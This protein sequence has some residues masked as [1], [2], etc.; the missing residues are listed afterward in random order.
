MFQ[1][2]NRRFPFKNTRKAKFRDFESKDLIFLI[3][4]VFYFIK[5]FNYRLKRKMSLIANVTQ[6][7]NNNYEKLIFKSFSFHIY[8][9]FYYINKCYF[10][11]NK[12]KL[13][14]LKITSR[15]FKLM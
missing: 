7:D 9:I 3:L 5:I 6:L 2:V 8:K 4:G 12:F 15:E 10:Y 14:N 1:I 11:F 13:T